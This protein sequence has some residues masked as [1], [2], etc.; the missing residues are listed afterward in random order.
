M[1]AAD[2]RPLRVRLRIAETLVL[3]AFLVLTARAA[4]LTLLGERGAARGESQLVTA[5]TLPPERGRIV[6]R[7]G[8]EIAMTIAVP[9]IYAVPIEVKDA[10]ATTAEL[11]EILGVDAK[12]TRERLG[13]R[14][15][16]V[17]IDRWADPKR[18]EALQARGGLPGIGILEEPRRAYPFGPLAASVIG[19]ANIDGAGVRGIEQKENAW[20][21]GQPRRVAVERDARGQLLLGPGH[22]RTA[23][24][25]GDVALTIDVAMQA[26]AEQALAA[27]VASARAKGG[28]VVALEPSSG[29]ILALAE[30]PRFDP[31]EFRRLS[32][33][34]T[35]SR[36]FT[37]AVEPGSTFKTFLI[38]AALDA[39]VVKPTDVFDLRG[40]ISVPGKHIKDL[41]PRPALDV[42]GILRRS[43]NVGSVKIAQKLGPA[44][45]YD[46]LRRFGFGR[47]TGSGFPDESHG[48]LRDHE[49]WRPV[50]AATVAFGQ[51]V[52]VTTVQLAAGIAALAND[53]TWVRPRLVRGHRRPG[54]AWEMTPAAD[55]QQA[56][57][58]ETAAKMLAMLEG[59]VSGEGGTGKRAQLRGLR[60]GG[61][62]GTAQKL[63][64]KSGRYAQDRYVAWFIG[65]APID[66]PRIAIAVGIDEPKGVHTGGAVAAPVFARVAAAILTQ[67]GIPTE[68]VLDPS[69]QPIT[70]VAAKSAPAAL[71]AVAAGDDA[72][73]SPADTVAHEG[74][75]LLVPDV[76][77]LTIAEVK[78]LTAGVPVELEIFGQGRAVA[79]EPDPGTVLAKGRPRLRVRFT[80]SGGEG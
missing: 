10:D 62:T 70:R 48:L 30:L 50:D 44:M 65:F 8:T 19:F 24:A 13:Q 14:R 17:Y 34:D 76:L 60:V 68:P 75:R 21:L 38:A 79:Q 25:G 72:T 4:H 16:F 74:G 52:S 40:G 26:E 29:D 56:V 20:L 49:K 73:P 47:R 77:G 66:D 32:F 64:T 15:A 54:G 33:P 46:T 51:G 1:R 67:M 39:G 9:S 80:E 28:Y 53:G 3:A 36:S 22:D 59:V 18:V 63:D 78:R 55:S 2:L 42:S 71:P 61:K 41:H 57:S 12:R 45:H 35:R 7:Q 43:S 5:L 6:D 23:T 37:D 69:G 27:G 31:N 11:V 58:P